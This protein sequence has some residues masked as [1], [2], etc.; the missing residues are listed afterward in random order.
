MGYGEAKILRTEDREVKGKVLPFC[1]C[2]SLALL[3]T[4]G[5][6]F[7]S[8]ESTPAPKLPEP[9]EVVE[10]TLTPTQTHT[11]APTLTSSTTATATSTFTPTPTATPAIAIKC[12]LT[13]LTVADPDVLEL[14]PLAVKVSNSAAARPHTGLSLADMVFDHLTEGGITRF[15]AIYFCRQPEVVGSIRSARLIDLELVPMFDAIFAYSGA[16]TGVADRIARSPVDK[17]ALDENVPCF[18]RAQGTGR[19][20]EHTLFLNVKKLREEMQRRGLEKKVELGK[21]AFSEE[22][23][24]GG[25]PGTYLSIPYS[26]YLSAVEYRYDS[27][28]K[29]YW[30]YIGGQAHLEMELET[31]KTTQIT[32][33][34]IVVLYAPTR[35]T[36]IIEDALGSRSLEID[37]QGEGKA[38]ILRDGKVYEAQW[39][40][41]KNQELLRYL[42][43][44]GRPLS[45]RPGNTWVQVVPLG[46]PV[47]IK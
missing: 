18:F 27:V 5:C 11:P 21:L 38:L 1:L 25:T 44:A 20:Y 41:E 24:P 26:G 31:K 23:P 12:P 34:N 9:T 30:R 13:G 36:A 39:V 47:T 6:S 32:A 22:P 7:G 8:K 33:T 42:D 17:V 14:R 40:R 45:L 4:G 3:L 10:V 29:L 46:F 15:T 37:L 28:R 19:A 43:Q 2:L 16:S 35:E